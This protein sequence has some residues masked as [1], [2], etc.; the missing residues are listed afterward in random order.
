MFTV[1]RTSPVSVRFVYAEDF[2]SHTPVKSPRNPLGDASMISASICKPRITLDRVSMG[3]TLKIRVTA[4]TPE[5]KFWGLKERTAE[6]E[7]PVQLQERLR[8]AKVN[9][10]LKR[11]RTGWFIEYLNLEG[12]SF[13]TIIYNEPIPIPFRICTSRHVKDTA[14]VDVGRGTISSTWRPD[15]MD[16]KVEHA[17]FV[18]VYYK[19]PDSDRF[20]N[21]P[22]DIMNLAFASSLKPGDTFGEAL[23]ED[24]T[25][26]LGYDKLLDDLGYTC[27]SKGDNC[28]TDYGA[29]SFPLRCPTEREWGTLPLPLPLETILGMKDTPDHSWPDVVRSFVGRK[30]AGIELG[31]KK[32]GCEPADPTAVSKRR[33]TKC[34]VDMPQPCYHGPS[35]WVRRIGRYCIFAV[36]I[37]D[38]LVYLLD[39]NW[40]DKEVALHLFATE[41]AAAAY[42]FG[43]R[44]GQI[45]WQAHNEGWDAED[46][47]ENWIRRSLRRA[48]DSQTNACLNPECMNGAPHETEQTE[49][50]TLGVH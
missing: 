20:P 18:R 30:I 12:D 14:V 34:C 45:G 22:R 11:C 33:E 31:P 38:T 27:D 50:A 37:D 43:K 29:Y 23:P 7:L 41:E 28:V 35:E 49:Q 26:V 48:N 1:L 24:R 44:G 4:P 46:A 2:I 42:C 9:K 39:S 8:E 5:M 10:W 15:L 25:L 3:P 47:V 13:A 32:G 21:S 36:K 19:I 16:D 6:L 40:R 17:S